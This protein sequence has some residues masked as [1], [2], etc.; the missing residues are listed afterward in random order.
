MVASWYGFFFF[1]V[2]VVQGVEVLDWPSRSSD[3]NL[4]ESIW[5]ELGR[6]VRQQVNP[7]QTLGGLER[8]LVEQWRRL[9][10]A[11]FTNA[12]RSIRRRYVAVRDA[13]GGHNR[14]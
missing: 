8:A 3:L 11:V 7:A 5:D 13:R 10:L 2:V 14:Y 12:L 6:R 1:D 4:I 9:P